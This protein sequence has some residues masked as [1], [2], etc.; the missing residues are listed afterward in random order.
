M[1]NS[2]EITYEN[3]HT[4]TRETNYHIIS[5]FIKIHRQSRHK[6]FHRR[7]ILEFQSTT[8]QTIITKEETMKLFSKL[9]HKNVNSS[10][11]LMMK[12]IDEFK[13]NV[14]KRSTNWTQNIFILFDEMNLIKNLK[15]KIQQ[16]QIEINI[17]SKKQKRQNIV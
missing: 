12:N 11:S 3:S 13:I 6:Q 8:Q 4:F 15:Q 9:V 16:K 1:K 7:F 10:I 2:Q 5:S 17:Q 14:I